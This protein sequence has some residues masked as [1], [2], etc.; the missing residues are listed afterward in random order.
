M[1][2]DIL[3]HLWEK[4]WFIEILILLFFATVFLWQ[5]IK[6]TERYLRWLAK[7]QPDS[8]HAHLSLGI[9]LKEYEECYEEAV[10]ELQQAI[11]IDPMGKDARYE[12]YMLQIQEESNEDKQQLEIV[13]HGLIKDFQDDALP[14]V[15]AGNFYMKEDPSRSEDYYKKALLLAPKYLFA[16][17]NYFSFLRN[18]KR[19]SEAEELLKTALE[20]SPMSENVQKNLLGVLI[21]QEK[22]SEA[23]EYARTFVNAHSKDSDIRWLFGSSLSLQGRNDE[24]LKIFEEIVKR[25]PEYKFAYSSMGVIHSETKDYEQ[26]ERS[27]RKALEI[28]PNDIELMECLGIVLIAMKRYEEAIPFY[29]AYLS[30]KP[31]DMGGLIAVAGAYRW[32]ENLDEQKRYLEKARQITAKDN[33]YDHACIESVSGNSDLAFDYLSKA[34]KADGFISKWAWEDPDLQWIRND[35]RFLEIAGPKP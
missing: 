15:W 12:L 31:D 13:L 8:Y 17:Q 20:I 6:E 22:Y 32:M 11:S 19:L 30:D 3:Q 10:S 16:I 24:A 25:D 28:D 2:V 1:L 18:Q 33:W 21:S 7:M 4:P 26:A 35:P 14:L 27:Y 29:I 5:K 23:E 34:S 9:Y